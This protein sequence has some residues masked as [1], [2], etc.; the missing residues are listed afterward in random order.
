MSEGGAILLLVKEV[1]GSGSP[2]M[3]L[4]DR[5]SRK[6][7]DAMAVS[8]W[9]KIGLVGRPHGLKGDFF[10]SGRDSQVP[11]TYRSIAIGSDP[12]SGEKAEILSV[13]NQNGQCVMRCTASKSRDQAALICGWPIW[14]VRDQVECDPSQNYLWADLE[15]R[16]LA[17][18]NGVV[19]GHVSRVYNV[20]AS[21]I[22]VIQDV[23]GKTLEIAIAP[24]YFDAAELSGRASSGA[25]RLQVPGSTFAD[26]WQEKI[27]STL[28][29]RGTSSSH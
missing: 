6:P 29:S 8:Q 1:R 19:L 4:P 13:R 14:V 22:L 9:V 25:V 11:D 18:C 3:Y 23:S 17:D 21:D 28:D 20:G 16:E 27:N 15:G 5:V 10:V 24:T 2:D 7:E 12:T 26:L